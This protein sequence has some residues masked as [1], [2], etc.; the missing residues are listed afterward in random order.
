MGCR[1]VVQMEKRAENRA[2]RHTG[3]A[4]MRVIEIF[5]PCQDTFN[6]EPE[7]ADSC[8]KDAQF[9]KCRQ[10]DLIVYS[11]KGCQRIE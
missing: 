7:P 8:T 10:E 3:R 5:V 6:V 4:A 1:D 9:R 11:V 2:L